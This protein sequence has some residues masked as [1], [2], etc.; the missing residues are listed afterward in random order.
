M[1]EKLRE[2]VLFVKKI[3][4]FLVSERK[5]IIV[6]YSNRAWIA[7]QKDYVNTITT[8]ITVYI[9]IQNAAMAR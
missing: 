4:I 5:N 2:D 3:K 1:K 7:R 6:N 9:V 8:N